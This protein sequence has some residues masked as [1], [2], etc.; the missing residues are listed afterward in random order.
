MFENVHADLMHAHRNHKPPA[1]RETVMLL[2]RNP[3]LQALFIYRFGR[4]LGQV[5]QRGMAIH[6]FIV[7]VLHP[8]YRWLMASASM[9]YGIYIEQSADIGPGFYIGHLGGIDVRQCRIGA[10]CAIGQQVKL[11]PT[12]CQS[13][14]PVIGDDVWI[15]A[16]AQ[17]LGNIAIGDGATVGA[18]SIVTRDIPAGCLVLGNPARITQR[19]Y[20]NR[21]FL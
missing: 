6:R 17:I 13:D 9:A 5:R 20:D 3:G 10:R 12:G 21:S 15:G 7:I 11:G 16:H 4:W 8:I 18:G 1:A 19:D 14:G 2:W